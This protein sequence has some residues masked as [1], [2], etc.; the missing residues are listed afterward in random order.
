MNFELKVG[1]CMAANQN[2]NVQ[3]PETIR[4]EVAL[5]RAVRPAKV[6][7]FK[8]SLSVLGAHTP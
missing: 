7:P 1:H 4:K 3:Y 2:L 6:L 5:K 8:P